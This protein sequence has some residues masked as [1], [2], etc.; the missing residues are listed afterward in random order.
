MTRYEFALFAWLRNPLR[1]IWVEEGKLQMR[2]AEARLYL[3][4]SGLL[5]SPTT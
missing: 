1:T 4:A 3:A 5:L 2:S